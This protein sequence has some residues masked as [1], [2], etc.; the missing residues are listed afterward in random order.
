MSDRLMRADDVRRVVAEHGGTA[1]SAGTILKLARAGEVPI[2]G[3]GKGG[4]LLFGDAAPR[5]LLRR[6][7]RRR[8]GDV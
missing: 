5:A 8:E 4:V 2:A 7:Q 1:L 3:R 6:E